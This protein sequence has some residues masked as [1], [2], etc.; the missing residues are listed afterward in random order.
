[1]GI[2]LPADIARATLLITADSA[3]ELHVNGTL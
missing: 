1:M 2:D 3:Y